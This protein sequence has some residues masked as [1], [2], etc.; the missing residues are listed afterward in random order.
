M[1]LFTLLLTFYCIKMRLDGV[2]GILMPSLETTHQCKF[3]FNIGLFI[4]DFTV[5]VLNVF[6][7]GRLSV[8]IFLILCIYFFRKQLKAVVLPFDILLLASQMVIVCRPTKKQREM[9]DGRD[10]C[11][12]HTTIIH[13]I[14]F[15]TM[16]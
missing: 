6:H 1:L 7:F 11:S 13:S 3:N 16:G 9:D 10:I 2:F 12:W 15:G 14:I 8:F 5:I 4:V